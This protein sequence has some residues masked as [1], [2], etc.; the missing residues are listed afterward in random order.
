MAGA[1]EMAAMDAISNSQ[2]MEIA[3]LLLII[4]IVALGVLEWIIVRLRGQ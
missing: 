4:G 1:Q 3:P 2:L